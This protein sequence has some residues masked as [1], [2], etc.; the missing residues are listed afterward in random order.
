MVIP[1]KRISAQWVLKYILLNSFANCFSAEFVRRMIRSQ[2]TNAIANKKVKNFKTRI[3][4]IIT[5]I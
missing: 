5:N 3:K 4:V 2:R 1:S